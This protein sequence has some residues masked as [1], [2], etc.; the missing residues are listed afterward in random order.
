MNP[1]DYMLY[2]LSLHSREHGNIVCSPYTDAPIDIPGLFENDEDALS[3]QATGPFGAMVFNELKND[4]FTIHHSYYAPEQDINL[5]MSN[6]ESFLGIHV[7]LR[8]NLRY[9]FDD[10]PGAFP[11]IPM[12]KYQ[13]N[14]VFT[15]RVHTA[16]TLHKGHEYGTFAIHYS[17]GYLE[18]FIMAIPQLSEFLKKV[19]SNLPAV[20][21]PVNLW[22]TLELRSIIQSIL[23]CNFKGIQKKMYLETK[24]HELILLAFQNMPDLALKPGISLRQSDLEKLHQA[25]EYIIQH[26]DNPGTLLELAHKV[27]INDFKLKQGFKQ[28]YG[29]TVFG[30]VHE[31]RMQKALTLLRETNMSILDISMLTGYKNASNFTAAF[32]KR[33]GYPPSDLKISNT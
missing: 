25:R 21:S 17:R 19:E 33:F 23:Y 5:I 10:F 22:S 7:N 1:A 13:Y 30:L 2:K 4:H 18:R 16:Y 9:V 24:M 3:L 6:E 12:L 8:N 14:M 31:E 15:P 29:T 20:I 28:I 26:L 27:G 32:R 11:E